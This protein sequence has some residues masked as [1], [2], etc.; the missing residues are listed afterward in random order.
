MGSWTVIRRLVETRQ[1]VAKKSRDPANV[2]SRGSLLQV[3]IVLAG[4]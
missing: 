2:G 4:G 1:L 3:E